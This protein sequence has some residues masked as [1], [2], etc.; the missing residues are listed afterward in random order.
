ML[1]GLLAL[2]SGFRRLLFE[3]P[4]RMVVLKMSVMLLLLMLALGSVTVWLTGMLMGQFVPEGDAWYMELLNILVWLFAVMLGFIV[5]L[6]A[7]MTLGSVMASAWLDDLV[8]IV[9]GHYAGQ[10]GSFWLSMLRSMKNIVMPLLQFLPYALLALLMLIVPVVGG[11]VASLIWAYAGLRLLAYEIMDASA[12]RRGWDWERRKQEFR[13]HRGFY[14]G[15]CV[16][17]MAAMMVPLLNL[18]V[19]PA[20]VVGLAQWLHLRDE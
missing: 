4:F 14:V 7:Y 20:A 9:E 17:T 13:Q 6:L 3:R 19:L 1:Q 15:L 8:G 16:A 12:N 11:A 18:F 10:R 5:G 2:V